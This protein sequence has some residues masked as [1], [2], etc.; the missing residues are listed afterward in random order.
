MSTKRVEESGIVK[1]PGPQE[2]ADLV[3]EET[4]GPNVCLKHP[5]AV[6]YDGPT[7]PACQAEQEFRNLTRG[8]LYSNRAKP[9]DRKGGK[10]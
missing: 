1:G 3:E 10:P 2:H 7:C 8:M 5:R 9:V 4:P 6:Y